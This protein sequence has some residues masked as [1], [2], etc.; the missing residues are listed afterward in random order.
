EV[1]PETLEASLMLASQLL[2]LLEVPISGVVRRM[3]DARSDRYRLLRGF[4]PGQ[5]HYALGQPESHSE[6]LHS[7]VL[8]EGAYAVGRTLEQLGLDKLGVVVT[9]VRRGGI[10]GP[11]PEP[12]TQ[13]RAGDVLILY[14][15]PHALE[16]AEE[17]LLKG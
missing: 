1:V 11:Q 8:P 10:R 9:A 4:F 5:E 17:I 13:L 7:A 12:Y 2:L 14:G 15:T 6:R 3:D 16:R